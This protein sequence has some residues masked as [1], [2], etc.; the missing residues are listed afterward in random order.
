MVAYDETEY[1]RQYNDPQFYYPFT[2]R[3]QNLG[4]F[5]FEIPDSSKDYQFHSAKFKYRRTSACLE[6]SYMDQFNLFGE[7]YE[8]LVKLVKT[9]ILKF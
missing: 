3:K 8:E 5:K 4:S 1:F 9:D 2:K 7:I 6:G